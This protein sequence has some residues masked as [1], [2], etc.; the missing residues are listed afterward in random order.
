[1]ENT[2]R[3]KMQGWKMQEYASR[4]ENPCVVEWQFARCDIRGVM[5]D[6]S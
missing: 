3:A 2:I 5:Q 4:V 6:S 1:M